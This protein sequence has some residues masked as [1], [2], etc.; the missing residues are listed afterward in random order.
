MNSIFLYI[1]TIIIIFI[2]LIIIY[3]YKDKF[4][5]STIPSAHLY[6]GLE[7]PTSNVSSLLN[8]YIQHINN[9]STTI[10]TPTSTSIPISTPSTTTQSI[11]DHLKSQLKDINEYYFNNGIKPAIEINFWI[12]NLQ[13]RLDNVQLKLT[14]SNIKPEQELLFY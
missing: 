14:E 9:P 6:Q 13:S 12:D 2:L 11:S 8:Q 7:Y 10:A 4:L 3:Y 1:I 5:V